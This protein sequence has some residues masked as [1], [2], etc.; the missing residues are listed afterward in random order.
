MATG[1]AGRGC[2]SARPCIQPFLSHYFFLKPHVALLTGCKCS[3]PVCSIIIIFKVTENSCLVLRIQ[4]KTLEEKWKGSGGKLRKRQS[5]SKISK[6]FLDIF[7]HPQD[8]EVASGHLTL[9]TCGAGQGKVHQTKLLFLMPTQRSGKLYFSKSH[10]RTIQN[11][12]NTVAFQYTSMMLSS[13]I[14]KYS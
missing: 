8:E 12:E 3:R 13:K 14:N 7:F 2:Q 9:P 6:H 11:Q 10:L 5:C 1:G 4:K